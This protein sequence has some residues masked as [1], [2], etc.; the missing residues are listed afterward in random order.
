MK[1]GDYLIQL[2]RMRVAALWIPRGG[3]V[4][5]IGCHQGEFLS[6]LGEK[7]VPSVGFD[8]LYKEG[9]D[10]GKHQFYARSFQEGL[11][12][13]KTFDAITMLATLEHI[14]DKASI[15]RESARLLRPGGRVVITVPSPLVD[16]VLDFLVMVH[17]VDGMSLEEHHGFLPDELPGIFIPA[18][19]RLRHIRKFQLGL[20]NLF[21]FERL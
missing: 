19:F 14:H 5:D 8:P 7:I 4:L 6:W 16:R 15:A 3:R 13:E 17:I 11:L 21:V 1:T 12:F 18:G 9:A 10:S 2:W 20:N